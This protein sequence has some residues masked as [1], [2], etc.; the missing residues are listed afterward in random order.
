MDLEQDAAETDIKLKEIVTS[1]NKINAK[2]QDLKLEDIPY[3][4]ENDKQKL[5]EYTAEELESFQSSNLQYKS[6]ILEEDLSKLKPNVQ[7]I[8]VRY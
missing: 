5:K 2:L 1:L 4:S 6:N 8:E 3:E 7:A